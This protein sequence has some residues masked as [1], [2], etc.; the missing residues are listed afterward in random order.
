MKNKTVLI[1]GGTGSFGKSFV[2]ELLSNKD[3]K[4]VIVFSRDELK[5]YHMRREIKDKRLRFFIGDIRDLERLRRAFSGVDIIVHAAALKQVPIL[6]YNPFE[7]VKTNIIGTQNIIEAAIDSKIE[8]AILISTDKAAYPSNLYGSTKLCAERL[9]IAAN[10]YSPKTRFAAV[11]YGNVIA[12]R[13]SFIEDLLKCN[14]EVEITDPKMTRFW[15]SLAQ[16][17]DLVKFAL[18]NMEGGEIFIPKIPSMS[19]GELVNILAP[20]A[21]TKII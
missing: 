20:K 6:E 13:G 9:L 10:S 11:R 12:S 4:K 3:I 2:R 5:Q 1:T 15:I 16:T 7:A 18:E 8:R 14:G 21:T 19:V 17:N